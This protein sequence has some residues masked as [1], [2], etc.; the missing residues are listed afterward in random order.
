MSSLSSTLNAHELASEQGQLLDL[1]EKLQYAQLENVKLPQVV[2]VGDQSAG[3]SSV[4]EAITGIPF[5][6]GAGA[7]TRFAT[8]IRLRRSA[9]SSIIVSIIPDRNRPSS[10]QKQLLGF[11]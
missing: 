6:R 3:K 4:L 10:E 5:P 11:G 2:V 8:E 1:L 7:C 9:E